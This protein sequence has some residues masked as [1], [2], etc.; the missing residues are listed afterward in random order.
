MIPVHRLLLLLIALMM[1][2]GCD[3]IT[4]DTK[5][6]NVAKLAKHLAYFKDEHGICYAMISTASY[7]SY[8]VASIATVPCEKVDL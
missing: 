4:N 7:G 2:V 3:P 6:A 5:P 1:L 8:N